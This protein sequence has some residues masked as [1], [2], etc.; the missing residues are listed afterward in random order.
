M[1]TMKTKKEGEKIS[2]YSTFEFKPPGLSCWLSVEFLSEKV[3]G[4]NSYKSLLSTML[5]NADALICTWKSGVA[6]K[7]VMYMSGLED[8]SMRSND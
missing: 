6:H 8:S 4:H 2:N 3:A 7:Y 5:A 1:T